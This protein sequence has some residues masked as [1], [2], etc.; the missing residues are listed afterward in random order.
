[1]NNISK[2]NH[3]QQQQIISLPHPIDYL[4]VLD[5]EATCSNV[6]K[7]EPQEIIEFPTLLLNVKTKKVESIFHYYIKPDVFPTLSDFCKDL[8]GI[9]QEQVNDGISLEKAL[10]EH[11]IWLQSNGLLNSSSTSSSPS[12]VYVTCGDWDL[13]TCLPKQLKYHNTKKSGIPSHFKR[14][15]NI[16][17]ESQKLYGQKAK[18]MVSALNF[19]G[20]EMEGRHHSGIDDSKNIARMCV[21]MIEDG[22]EIEKANIHC[23]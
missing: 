5:F 17:K 2:N 9:T 21:K 7:P 16:K 18:G 4:L 22:W 19:L 14:W 15:I 6:K 8:T 12:F 1:M 23:S 3:T 20:L 10:E 13:K 11:E